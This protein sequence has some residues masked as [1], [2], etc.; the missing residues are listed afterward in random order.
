MTDK[1]GFPELAAVPELAPHLL[2]SIGLKVPEGTYLA[3][4]TAQPVTLEGGFEAHIIVIELPEE[5][6][7]VRN[8]V[9]AFVTDQMSDAADGPICW[10]RCGCSKQPEEKN[11]EGENRSA[12]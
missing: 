5:V 8:T 11:D 3:G 10:V 9:T 12:D 7:G 4:I 2:R 1:T 6:T